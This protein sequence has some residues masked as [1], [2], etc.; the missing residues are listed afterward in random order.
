VWEF[1][2][3]CLLTLYSFTGNEPL[4]GLI[5]T[6]LVALLATV[7]GEFTISIVFRLNRHHLDGLNSNLEK[8]SLLSQQAMECG[9]ERSYRALNKQAN[10]AYGQLFFNRFGLSAAS[11]WPAFFSLA[12]I[13]RHWAHTGI[14]IPFHPAGANYVA[15]FLFCYVPARILFGRIKR[16]LPYF[17]RQHAMLLAY[18]KKERA[19]G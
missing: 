5:G 17:K 13:Q 18:D 7:I 12:F 19:T 8:Y 16:H 3:P 6:F 4:D 11:L 14:P 1:F 15:V 2:D 9:D 10:E